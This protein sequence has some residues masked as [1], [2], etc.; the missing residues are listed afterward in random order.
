MSEPFPQLLSP[1]GSG[2]TYETVENDVLIDQAI[3]V[4]GPVDATLAVNRSGFL[5]RVFTGQ[6]PAPKIIIGQ[7]LTA[8]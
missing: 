3:P 7:V 8:A 6:S 2:Q 1:T 4:P 5:A